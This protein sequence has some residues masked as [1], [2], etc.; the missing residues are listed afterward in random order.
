MR[1]LDSGDLEK[2]LDFLHHLSADTQ[3]RFGPHSFDRQSVID[4]YDNPQKHW[5]V[6][7]EDLESGAIVAYFVIKTGYLEHDSARLMSYGLTLDA[8][9]DCTFAPAVADDW[10]SLGLGNRLWGFS[11][12]ELKRR[13]LRRVI[14]WGGVQSDN[15]RAV[16]FYRKNG[17][18]WLGRFEYNG[19]NDDM[20]LTI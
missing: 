2:L 16:N 17:F 14:L 1:R 13:G 9:T 4:F 6:V 3:K 20:I 5:A 19:W 18:R 11:L 12:T 8:Q 10:Q 15:E 7:A